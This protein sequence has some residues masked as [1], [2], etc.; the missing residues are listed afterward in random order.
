M[1]V[2]ITGLIKQQHFQTSAC[3]GSLLIIHSAGG[4]MA[5]GSYCLTPGLINQ[6]LQQLWVIACALKFNNLL[7]EAQH[8]ADRANKLSH[9]TNC[10]CFCE[11]WTNHDLRTYSTP[12]PLWHFKL[13]HV[14]LERLKGSSCSVG[15]N[16]HTSNKAETVHQVFCWL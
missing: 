8:S 12:P 4:Q 9:R 5:L 16:F 15:R 11:S 3:S 6:F 7:Y 14:V 13:K 2:R 10:T 1:P